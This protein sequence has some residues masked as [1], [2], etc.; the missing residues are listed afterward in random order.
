MKIVDRYIFS[1][2]IN[3]NVFSHFQCSLYSIPAGNFS[4]SSLLIS[5]KDVHLY[6]MVQHHSLSK[7]W[8]ILSSRK[9]YIYICIYITSYFLIWYES[10]L[11][12]I[13]LHMQS[14]LFLSCKK[15]VFIKHRIPIKFKIIFLYRSEK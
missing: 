6:R 7:N 9:I 12:F 3:F 10:I 8:N 1:S 13:S 5:S 4:H 2:T 11:W 15:M 14:Y